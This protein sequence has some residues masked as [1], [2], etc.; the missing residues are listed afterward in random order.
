MSRLSSFNAK[1]IIYCDKTSSSSDV[2]IGTCIVDHGSGLMTVGKIDN[3]ERLVQLAKAERPSCVFLC[4]VPPSIATTLQQHLSDTVCIV[5]DRVIFPR[6]TDFVEQ[7]FRKL[8]PHG[9]GDIAIR[10]FGESWQQTRTLHV[11]TLI[12]TIHVIEESGITE[13]IWFEPKMEDFT[14]DV[15]LDENTLEQLD[16]IQ[17]VDT[18][19]TK[20]ITAQGNKMLTRLVSFPS[21]SAEV[22]RERQRLLQLFRNDPVTCDAVLRKLKECIEGEQC[23]KKL[24]TRKKNL[25]DIMLFLRWVRDSVEVCKI[26]GD[27]GGMRDDV[28]DMEVF[29]QRN[30]IDIY[31][32]CG[33]GNLVADTRQCEQQ[34]IEYT[35]L[36]SSLKLWEKRCRMRSSTINHAKVVDDG[37]DG[38]VR[39]MCI[40]NKNMKAPGIDFVPMKVGTRASNQEIDEICERM[41]ELREDIES[42]SFKSLE[43]C[44]ATLFQRF[45]NT[46]SSLVHHIALIDCMATHARMSARMQWAIPIIL[47]NDDSG[48]FDVTNVR[49]PIIESNSREQC[50]KN[51]VVVGREPTNEGLIIH[52]M[53]SC[54][55]S[56]LLKACTIS[57][58]LAQ[59]GL[60]VPADTMMLRPFSRVISQVPCR[61]DVVRNRSSFVAEIQS[62]DCMIRNSSSTTFIV[63][64]ELT[65]G[66]EYHSSQ[67]IFAATI[68][69]LQSCN[70]RFMM[71]THLHDMDDKL[72]A[73]GVDMSRLRLCHLSVSVTDEKVTFLRKLQDGRGDDNYGVRIA[74]AIVQDERFR[75]LAKLASS[76]SD[77]NLVNRKFRRCSYNHSTTVILCRVCGDPASDTHHIRHQKDADGTSGYFSDGTHKN[78]LSNLVHLCKK[79]HILVHN[80]KLNISGYI[81]TTSG[82]ELS[83]SHV[84]P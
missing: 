48:M 82:I 59:S 68:K 61:D 27:H 76:S 46:M 54:G 79:C 77:E 10:F 71:T 56:C 23:F 36:S 65:R 55:K 47:D 70:S 18:L 24:S 64:D 38:G 43:V 4:N 29:V 50:I 42:V 58:I 44:V 75:T 20:C 32:S 28:N 15:I 13:S 7:I 9:M 51:D 30:I 6:S 81:S 49:H 40:K 73:C 69:L 21:K 78:A 63:A 22:I 66:T 1:L 52:G 3:I 39:I 5:R 8:W 25:S 35:K 34:M 17:V 80:N 57:L 33:A 60:C 74:C 14:N 37:D 2:E 84:Y 53:N 11:M 12:H 31:V 45:L 26:A 83:Y 67:S 16:V 62:I 19:L 41:N 72:Y